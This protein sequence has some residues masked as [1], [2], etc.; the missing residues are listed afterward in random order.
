MSWPKKGIAIGGLLI[1]LLFVAGLCCLAL[2]GGIEKSVGD[3]LMRTTAGV[4]GIV[5]LLVVID[6]FFDIHGG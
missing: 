5:L 1:L 4:F 3:V 2:T 6:I